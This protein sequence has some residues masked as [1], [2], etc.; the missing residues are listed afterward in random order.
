MRLSVCSLAGPAIALVALGLPAVADATTELVPPGNSAASQY[1]EVVPSA[2]GAV[3]VGSNTNAHKPVLSASTQRRLR[4]LGSE[5]SAVA[6][7]AQATAPARP[8]VTR[9]RSSRGRA[10]HAPAARLSSAAEVSLGS[11][12]GGLGLGLP[13]ALGAIT[14]IAAAIALAR[15]RRPAG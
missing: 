13:I 1:V 4:A 3:P 11:G 12:S 5:G 10:P 14:F 2:G 15:R 6:A 8:T 7:L 9:G